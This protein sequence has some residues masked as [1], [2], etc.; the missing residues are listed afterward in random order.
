MAISTLRPLLE[1]ASDERYGVL[2]INI[3]NELTLRAVI[4]AAELRRSPVIVQTSVKT[5]KAHGVRETLSAFRHAAEKSTVPVV[6]HLDHCTDREVLSACLDAGWNSVLFDGSGLSLAEVTRQTIEVVQEAR[7][8][9]ADVEGEIE[10]IQGVEDGVGSDD[11]PTLYPLEQAVEFIQTTG[12]DCFA[13][14][15][16]NAHGNYPELPRL[17]TER[18]RALVGATGKPMALHGGSGLSDE[19]FNELIGLGCSKVNIST[20]LKA[21]YID[22]HR[23]FICEREP[24]YEPLNLMRYV[25]DRVRD[26]AVNYIDVFGSAGKAE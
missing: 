23:E 22:A 1:R 25:A 16:G 19:Q 26:V 12:V 10:G 15:I 2:A 14:A 5:V 7:R 21:A 9:G 6:L 20:A 4:E 13:P 17:D 24:D 3:V 11:A 18:V 8:L